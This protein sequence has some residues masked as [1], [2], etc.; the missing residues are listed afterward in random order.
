MLRLHSLWRSIVLW[1]RPERRTD[2]LC[3]FL[4][5]ALREHG[6]KVSAER[7]RYLAG[8][9]ERER[10]QGEKDFNTVN[11]TRERMKAINQSRR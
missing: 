8:K 3:P 5:D 7:D 10:A 1:L 9:Y 6:A 2:V 4:G 11:E